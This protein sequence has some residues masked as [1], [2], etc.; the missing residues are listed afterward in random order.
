MLSSTALTAACADSPSA[1]VDHQPLFSGNPGAGLEAFRRECAGCH[2]AGDAFDIAF[3]DF[4]DTAIVRRALRHVDTATA[5][6][7]VAHVR[8]VGTSGGSPDLRLFQPGGEVL[9]SD[10]EFARRLFGADRWPPDLDAAGLSR[11]DP[12]DVAVALAFPVWS[13]ATGNVD[14]MPDAP[15]D[16]ALLDHT[17]SEE[18]PRTLLSD[19]YRT[20]STRSLVRA[21]EALSLADRDPGVPV[22]PCVDGPPERFRP[23]ACFDVRRWTATLA[24]QHILRTGGDREFQTAFHGAWW[25]VGDAARRSRNGPLPL[26]N[27]LENWARW[28]YLGWASEPGLH[29][30]AT[31]AAPLDALELPRH[32]T[33][34]A[35]RSMVARPANS[36][37]PFADLETAARFAPPGWSYDAVRFGL[38]FLI[39]RL[40]TG[41]HMDAAHADEARQAVID[42]YTW[43]LRKETTVTRRAELLGLVQT[44]LH[45]LD[46][47]AGT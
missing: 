35:L 11:I 21:V 18:T 38:R 1:P 19:Y 25:D 37:A 4:P 10:V 17:S 30:S 20:R 15:I 24:A 8:T 13:D 36:A 39:G 46:A 33:F 29:P 34:I 44:V 42:A 6:D 14:W 2:A 9:A 27:S 23:Q 41:L 22:A 32:A 7:V 5:H 31:L 28:M 16:P 3:F 43:T 47:A 45:G 40:E 12:R 26:A